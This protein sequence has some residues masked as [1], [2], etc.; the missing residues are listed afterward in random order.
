MKSQHST[1]KFLYESEGQNITGCLTPFR[2]GQP[3]LIQLPENPN[4]W[5]AVFSTKYKME[6][7]CVDLGIENYAIKQITD[8]ID[9]IE[10]IVEHGI[11]IM[12]DPYIL[13]SENKTR[14]TEIVLK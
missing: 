5:V 4:F 1:E 13:R 11:R 2:N 3:I 9:F 6:E 14:W 8:G 7:S 10:S 12:L